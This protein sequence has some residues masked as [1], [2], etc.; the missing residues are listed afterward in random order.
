MRLV[1]HVL[2]TAREA[3]RKSGDFGPFGAVVKD[4]GE[5]Q[6]YET[7]GGDEN[8]DRRTIYLLL[9]AGFAQDAARGKVLASTLVGLAEIPDEIPAEN[10]V[11]IAIAVE[12]PRVAQRIYVPYTRSHRGP[13]RLVGV[14]P[15]VVCY[16]EPVAVSI[17]G[18]V[19]GGGFT[20]M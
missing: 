18:F 2:G 19:F 4:D 11:S 5:I 16:D 3:L 6:M 8:A 1:E 7:P 14:G 12:T 15:V 9:R 13:L 17:P 10:R 20:P